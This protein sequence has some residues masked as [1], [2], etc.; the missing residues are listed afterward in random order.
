MVNIFQHEV[1]INFVYPFLLVFFI[2]FAILEKTK[3]LGDGKGQLNAFISLIISLIFVAAV[4]PAAVVNNLML[5]LV[6]ALVVFFVVLLLWGFV[7]GGDMKGG[8]ILK[9][10]WLKIVVVSVILIGILVVIL[11]SVGVGVSKIVD[12]L[13]HQ[14]WSETFWTS[15]FFV[16]LIAIVL[17]IVIGKKASA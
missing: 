1:A 4:K 17:A 2:V 5:F 8:D 16:V 3:A 14:S 7:S 15:A 12:V 11:S 6:I 13:F 10:K 9:S